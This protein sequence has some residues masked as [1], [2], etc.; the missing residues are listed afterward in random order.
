M[1]T[2]IARKRAVSEEV[3]TCLKIPE[4]PPLSYV[5]VDSLLF[6]EREDRGRGNMI[7]DEMTSLSSH[8]IF[9]IELEMSPS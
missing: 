4:I 3:E 2:Y 7:R 5:W 9:G 1:P 8:V 6:T